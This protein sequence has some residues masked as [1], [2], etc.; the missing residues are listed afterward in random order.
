MA[1]KKVTKADLEAR[2]QM[3]VTAKRLRDL[4]EKAQAE[5][6]RRES[7]SVREPPTTR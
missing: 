2:E 6:D 1:K 5:V 7:A 3:L 4:A